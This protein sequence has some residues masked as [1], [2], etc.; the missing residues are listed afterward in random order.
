MS[1]QQCA[2][3][4]NDPKL[5]HEHTVKRIARFLLKTKDKGLIF[6]PNKTL[7]LTCYV[8]ADWAG[9]WTKRSS[10]DPL[11]CHSRTEYVIKYAG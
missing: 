10:M 3:F 6:H 11:S 5:E 8:D 2:Y 9:Q 1:V 7:R 4:C